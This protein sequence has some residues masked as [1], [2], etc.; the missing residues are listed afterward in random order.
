MRRQTPQ[1]GWLEIRLVIQVGSFRLVIQGG[2]VMGNTAFLFRMVG[3]PPTTLPF[4]FNTW[5]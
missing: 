5:I 3:F 2:A 4:K 1:F